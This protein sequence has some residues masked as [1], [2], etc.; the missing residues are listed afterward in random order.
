MANTNR[1]FNFNHNEYKLADALGVDNDYLQ[2]VVKSN[3]KVLSDM[4]ENSDSGSEIVESLHNFL[5]DDTI[6][7]IDKT[8]MIFLTFDAISNK[9]K[10]LEEMGWLDTREFIDQIMGE[11]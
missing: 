6:P 10:K 3:I 4:F 1:K 7:N 5:H 2:G 9:R 11:G 8:I